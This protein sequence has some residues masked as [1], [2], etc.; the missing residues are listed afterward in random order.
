MIKHPLKESLEA[1]DETSKKKRGR[2]RPRKY[3]NPDQYLDSF[4]P[5]MSDKDFHD[6]TRDDAFMRRVEWACQEYDRKMGGLLHATCEQSFII[7]PK[8]EKAQPLRRTS[9]ADFNIMMAKK[10]GNP[11]LLK[12]GRSYLVSSSL[13]YALL[14]IKSMSRRDPS[15]KPYAGS[16]YITAVKNMLLKMTPLSILDAQ[17]KKLPG[18]TARGLFPWIHSGRGMSE[19]QG[20][21][22]EERIREEKAAQRNVYEWNEDDAFYGILGSIS[23]ETAKE[24]EG[25]EI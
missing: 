9:S 22:E 15:G 20:F 16:Y 2:G 1:A 19:M 10:R 13:S 21:G 4:L 7:E 6:L 14:K 3:F 24:I 17:E 5:K 23:S 11:S 12:P 18:N 8:K 25:I